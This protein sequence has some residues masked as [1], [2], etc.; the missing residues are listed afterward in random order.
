[1]GCKKRPLYN[2]RLHHPNVSLNCANAVIL[3]LQ[4]IQANSVLEGSHH[5]KKIHTQKLKIIKTGR[6]K[7][8]CNDSMGHERV[9]NP[10]GLPGMLSQGWKL[11][12]SCLVW[13]ALWF[14]GLL[15]VEIRQVNLCKFYEKYSKLLYCK[16]VQ[17]EIDQLTIVRGSCDL[18]SIVRLGKTC[19]YCIFFCWNYVYMINILSDFI[20][21]LFMYACL[22]TYTNL[23]G[24]LQTLDC[25]VLNLLLSL[26]TSNSD[27]HDFRRNTPEE[28]RMNGVG[29]NKKSCVS[30]K[31]LNITD[32]GT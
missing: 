22:H 18:S 4:G 31:S 16:W 13:S 15:M 9:M 21:Y 23:K 30:T 24:K 27:K 25:F 7:N 17:L 14:P 3:L 10:R 5:Q 28:R 1:M 6:S 26:W 12:I 29:F 11:P 19:D 20:H 8:W 32:C 2:E